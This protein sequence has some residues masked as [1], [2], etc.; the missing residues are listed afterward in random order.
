MKGSRIFYVLL[1]MLSF[2]ACTS[3]QSQQQVVP[4]SMSETEVIKPQNDFMW[5]IN[6]IDHELTMYME[7][8]DA[9]MLYDG[10]IAHNDYEDSA[11]IGQIYLLLELNVLKAEVGN[12]PFSWSDTYVED[13]KGNIYKRLEEDLFIENHGYERLPATD[14]K[15][16][17]NQGFVVFEINEIA[18]EDTLYFVHNA[19]E[20]ENRIKIQ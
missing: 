14:L 12:M 18:A 15:L 16:G 13:A 11:Q 8:S 17:E 5:Q 2:T 19:A 1:I 10:S 7:S 4:Q 20:G 6:H 9:M 3:S